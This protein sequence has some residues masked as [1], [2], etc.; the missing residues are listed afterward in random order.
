MTLKQ[1]NAFKRWHVAHRNDHPVEY[2]FCD[3]VL[4]LWVAGWVGLLSAM[5][6]RALGLLPFLFAAAWAPDLYHALR[7]SLHH[8]GWLRCDWLAAVQF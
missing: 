3:A 4:S 6:L 7:R 5:I 1:L 8:H 2:Q